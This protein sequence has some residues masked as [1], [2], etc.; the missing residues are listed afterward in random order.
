MTWSPADDS[1]RLK[2][3]AQNDQTSKKPTKA[4]VVSAISKLY[5]QSGIYGPASVVGKIIMQDF[6]RFEALGWN[7]PAPR[8]WLNAGNNS[9]KT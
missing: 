9:T 5:D 4:D 2:M 7:D 1:L 8:T 6:W 3:V